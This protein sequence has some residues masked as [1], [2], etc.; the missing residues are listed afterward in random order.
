MA[1]RCSDGHGSLTSGSVESTATSLAFEMLSLLM[2]EKDLQVVEVALAVIAPRSVEYL[3]EGLT[4]S[5]L[6]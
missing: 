4:R 5:F 2:I 3:L 1:K 6:S